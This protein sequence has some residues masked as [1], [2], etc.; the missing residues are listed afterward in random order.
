MDTGNQGEIF[1]IEYGQP[2]QPDEVVVPWITVILYDK[3]NNK[4]GC[5]HDATNIWDYRL[6]SGGS[7]DEEDFVECAKREII[8][9]TGHNDF[10]EF[11]PIVP[12]LYSRY[13]HPKKWKN[14]RWEV[15]PFFVVMNSLRRQ[16]IALEEHEKWFEPV[17]VDIDQI[18][19]SLLATW[20]KRFGK[21]NYDHRLFLLD[22]ASKLA[23]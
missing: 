17:W 3:E 21:W 5:L 18:K 4:Y 13:W 8:E 6:I 15:R 14:F 7:K 22:E 19:A 23:K 9:E 16:E 2:E 11:I 12:I 1:V 20:D 10:A